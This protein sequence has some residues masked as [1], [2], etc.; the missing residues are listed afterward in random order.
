VELFKAN[1]STIIAKAGP[2]FSG[3]FAHAAE[4]S[5]MHNYAMTPGSFSWRRNFPTRIGPFKIHY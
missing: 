2:A 4:V 1:F 5:V 3:D